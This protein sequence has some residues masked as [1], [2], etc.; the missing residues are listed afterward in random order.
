MQDE[1]RGVA[2]LRMRLGTRPANFELVFRVKVRHEHGL[3]APVGTLT[4]NLDCGTVAPRQWV[5]AEQRQPPH[6]LL[7]LLCAINDLELDARQGAC[8]HI[9]KVEET[10][11]AHK[12]RALENMHVLRF[13]M[14]R[15]VDDRLAWD[16]DARGKDRCHDSI[17][18]EDDAEGSQARDRAD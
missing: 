18:P 12:F 2:G 11:G 3:R 6:K 7:R 15:T 8:L 9:A 10:F 1:V 4:R 14:L 17:L 13:A 5:A 16:R